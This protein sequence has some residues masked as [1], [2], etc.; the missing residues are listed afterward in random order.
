M[1]A[2]AATEKITDG[3]VGEIQLET[4]ATGT[5]SV[6]EYLSQDDSASDKEEIKII[7]KSAKRKSSDIDLQVNDISDSTD[8]NTAKSKSIKRKKVGTIETP[9][10]IPYLLVTTLISLPFCRKLAAKEPQATLG[11]HTRLCR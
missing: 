2:A 9:L 7:D 5:S 10:T 6:D 4:V 1:A 3:I 8:M 11:Q